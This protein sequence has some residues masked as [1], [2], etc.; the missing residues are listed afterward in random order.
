MA[1]ELTFSVEGSEQIS[2]RLGI[3]A[4]GVKNFREPLR[5]VGKDLLK[6]FDTNFSSRGAL[7]GGWAPRKPQYRNGV[8][9][10]TWP[11]MEKSGRMRRSFKSDVRPF[12]VELSN[13]ATYFKYHQSNAP[14]RSKLPRRAM[15]KLRAQDADH[16]VKTFQAYL[17]KLARQS[18]A[19]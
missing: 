3:T 12:T 9:V 16:I 4:E 19:R 14:R 5:E 1:L 15:M 11:L 18:G 13:R 10:D 8:R 17:V 2:R 7:Y 6:T